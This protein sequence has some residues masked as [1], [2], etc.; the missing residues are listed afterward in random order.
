[1]DGGEFDKDGVLNHHDAGSLGPEEIDFLRL[2]NN[3]FH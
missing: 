2:E 3:L 1:V